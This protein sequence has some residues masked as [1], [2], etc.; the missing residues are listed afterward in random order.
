MTINLPDGATS[1][2]AE[3]HMRRGQFR[4]HTVLSVYEFVCL[5]VCVFVGVNVL[6]RFSSISVLL[7]VYCV[8]RCS[9]NCRILLMHAG[10]I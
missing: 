7:Q 5:S 1:E 8:V 6:S 10:N 9:L 4:T 3:K 2:Y